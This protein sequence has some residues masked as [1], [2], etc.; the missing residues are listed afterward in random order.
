[1]ASI[2]LK[3]FLVFLV[4]SQ[5]LLYD[6]VDALNDAPNA[7]VDE[8]TK[9]MQMNYHLNQRH[10]IVKRKSKGGGRGFGFGR[11]SGSKS[12]SSSPSRDPYPKQP[13]HNPAY[14]PSAPAGGHGAPPAY[15]GT[16]SRPGAPPPYSAPGSHPSYPGAPPA[17]PGGGGHASYPGAPPAYPGG[18]HYNP[19][20]SQ[21]GC[22]YFS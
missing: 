10:H 20:Y 13:A 14:N 22:K 6:I 2:R 5:C 4:T 7:P 19:G 1:M 18:G 17:Y 15:P 8:V 12:K 9:E 16:N 3:C 11:K 21:P